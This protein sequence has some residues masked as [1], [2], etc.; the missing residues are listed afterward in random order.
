MQYT[1]LELNEILE[2]PRKYLD[3]EEGGFRANLCRADLSGADLSGVDL[4][5]ANL[6]N[7]NLSNANL[8]Y[9]NLSP[10]EPTKQEVKD[11]AP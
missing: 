11:A 6:S 3:N 2:V 7:A 8:S 5:R 1:K 9:A 4:C 10:C